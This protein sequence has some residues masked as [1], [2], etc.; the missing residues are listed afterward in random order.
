VQDVEVISDACLF[1]RR[2]VLEGLGWYDERYRLYFTE[3]D[4]CHRLWAAG[5]RVCYFPFARVRHHG[6]TSTR[7]APRLWLRW[8]TVRDLLAYARQYL[9]PVSLVGLAAASA[10]DL[11]LVA[12]VRGIKWL[13][14]RAQR[15]LGVSNA[16]A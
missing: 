11:T 14:A 16:A 15:A 3:D 1:A 9:G 13:V 10:V 8:L 5:W 6:S 4:L 12:A 7:K 2:A